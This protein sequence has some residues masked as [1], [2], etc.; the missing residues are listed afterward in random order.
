MDCF[1]RGGDLA[2]TY[3]D[4]PQAAMRTQI[5]WRAAPGTQ[6]TIATIELLVS[7]Q[8]S[9]LD[10]CPT[11]TTS[12]QIPADQ[13]LVWDDQTSGTFRELSKCAP[14]AGPG[15]QQPHACGYLYRLRDCHFS[16]AEM[17]HPADTQGTCC[18]LPDK[19]QRHDASLCH[20][21]F[22]ERLEKGVI[23]RAR[24]LG[25]FL[26]RAGDEEAAAAHFAAFLAA[27]P[28]LAV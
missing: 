4:R 7:V 18:E 6:G 3:S 17:A 14:P 21:L 23:L 28:P 26:D 20:T 9:L 11:M 2:I 8:T 10:S 24:V 25:V 22:A 27:D 16:Y 19:S 1:V 5:Y 12:S 13:S 15:N